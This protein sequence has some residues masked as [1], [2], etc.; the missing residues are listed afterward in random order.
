MRFGGEN[1]GDVVSVVSY[2]PKITACNLYPQTNATYQ[3]T[4]PP[5]HRIVQERK[6]SNNK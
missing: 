4:S 2:N 1:H 3:C 6:P 5:H